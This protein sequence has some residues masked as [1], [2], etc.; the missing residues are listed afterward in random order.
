[1]VNLQDVQKNLHFLNTGTSQIPGLI[2]MTLDSNEGDCGGYNHIVVVFNATL[3]TIH[4]QN[5]QLKGK[6]LFY[7][8][9]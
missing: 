8:P 1:M 6:G 2:V 7:I 4:F 5:D 9:S 3:N